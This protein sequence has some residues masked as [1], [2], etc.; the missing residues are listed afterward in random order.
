MSRIIPSLFLIIGIGIPSLFGQESPAPDF[1]PDRSYTANEMAGYTSFGDAAWRADGELIKGSIEPEGKGGWLFF[2]EVYQNLA[3]YA[4][5]KCEEPCD[6]G[7]VFRIEN[8]G[9]DSGA[10]AVMI[11]IEGETLHPYKISLNKSGDVTSRVSL[12]DPKR[13]PV[14]FEEGD[15]TSPILEA[16]MAALQEE[17]VIEAGG[18]NT[19]EVFLDGNVIFNHLNG[20]RN[21]IP[22]GKVVPPPPP[23]PAGYPGV[24]EP[25]VES[26]GL[27]PFALYLGS[28]S[29]EFGDVS[30]MDLNKLHFEKEYLSPDFT[31]QN[32]NPYYYAWGGDVADINQDGS[33]DVISGPFVYLGPEL[34]S[35]IEFY[36]ARTY[37]PGMQYINDMITF[38]ND[39]NGDGWPDIILTERRPLV[40]YVN[41]KG[42]KHYWERVEVLPDVCSETAIR[43]DIDGDGEPEIAYVSSSGQVS[44]GEPDP[45]DLNGP[46]KTYAISERVI[47]G[48]NAHGLG[49]GDVDGDGRADIVQA[50]G[51][52]QQPPAWSAQSKW[53]YHEANFGRFTRPSQH[54]GGAELAVYDFNND[55]LNDVV[56]SLS[57]HGWGLAWFE[58]QRDADGVISFVEHMIMDNFSTKN[59]GDVTFSQI[60]SGATLGDINRDG[61]M[62]FVTGKRHWSHLDAFTDPDPNGEAV[63]YW[64]ETVREEGAPGGVRFEP[65][66]IH[67]KSGVGSEVKVLDIDE[68]GMLDIV[69]SGTRGTFV[70]WGLGSKE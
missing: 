48:C 14:S 5:F 59:A 8:E 69:T 21:A 25:L 41:P 51:W 1:I 11:S 44:Y 18:W 67:N 63:I 52:W 12:Q 7:L 28:G 9:E 3:F 16:A 37:N 33:P 40:M 36:P 30:I 35:Y 32:L 62:D 45:A 57:A 39:W 46:W 13:S 23:G 20:V 60:H 54:P 47:T 49:V 70:F 58:Q 15:V 38:A 56:G 50:R 17:V 4:K 64:Y 66:L 29:V 2:D 34:E 10:K 68:D 65:H 31:V 22:G 6:A 26:Y 24:V 61:V 27:G 19:V 42:E 53:T 43:A 55:G